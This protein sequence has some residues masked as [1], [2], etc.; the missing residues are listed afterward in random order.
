MAHG[1]TPL[2]A[3][4][5]ANRWLMGGPTAVTDRKTTYFLCSW[6]FEEGILQK[7]LSLPSALLRLLCTAQ[8]KHTLS[9]HL[10]RDPCSLSAHAEALCRTPRDTKQTGR[11]GSGRSSPG[12]GKLQPHRAVIILE[13]KSSI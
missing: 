12:T 5:P 13:L 1:G 7:P 6:S 11:A 2:T 3:W 10:L 8:H 9:P 4:P